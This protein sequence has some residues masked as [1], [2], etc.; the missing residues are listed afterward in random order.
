MN[1]LLKWSDKMNDLRHLRHALTGAWYYRF[2]SRKLTVIGITGTDGKS[3]SVYLTAQILR[4]AGYKVG[5]FS[6]IAYSTGTED[7]M[8]T[9]KMSMPGRAYLQTFLSELVAN[10]CTHAVIEATS[11]GIK[12]YRH[13]GIGYDVIGYTNI[14]PEHIERHGSFATYKK[15]KLRL[16]RSLR[17]GG[18]IVINHDDPTLADLLTTFK[19]RGKVITTSLTSS[20]DISGTVVANTLFATTLNIKTAS[21][22][23]TITTSLGGP[24]IAPNILFAVA[25]TQ[26]LGLSLEHVQKAIASVTHIPGRFEVVCRQPVVIVDYAH[27]VAALKILLPYLRSQFSGNIIH[28]FG[29]AGGGRDKWKRT[30]MGRLS[31][32]YATTTILTEENPFDE[33]VAAINA[34]ILKGFTQPEQ[35]MQIQEREKAVEKARALAGTDSLVI[36]TGKGSETVIAGPKHTKKPYNEREFAR[37]RFNKS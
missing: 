24:F 10:G 21:E 36:L 33:P 32:Q 3:S 22:N 6:S 27:T 7:K 37:C 30:L 34:E 17:P 26:A 20:A 16:L 15:T 4:Q 12:Q 25:I 19:V 5:Y 13:V 8:N 28:V 31:E 11:E 9:F 2:P 1:F 29:A 18:R 23:A 35:V 14:T